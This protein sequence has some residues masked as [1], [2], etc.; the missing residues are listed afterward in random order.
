MHEENCGDDGDDTIV[1]ALAAQLAGVMHKLCQASLLTVV[2]SIK[3]A[4]ITESLAAL[5]NLI[6]AC[7]LW[8]SLKTA[9]VSE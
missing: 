6:P 3:S 7:R 8:T 9:L 2:A 1:Y 5:H 4:N